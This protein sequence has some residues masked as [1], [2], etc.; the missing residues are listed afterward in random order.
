MHNLRQ[1]PLPARQTGLRPSNAV[2]VHRSE[3]VRLGGRGWTFWEAPVIGK[4]ACHFAIDAAFRVAEFVRIPTRH[5]VCQEFSRIPLRKIAHRSLNV[6]H[7]S[8]IRA[9][10]ARQPRRA[11]RA[12]STF[13]EIVKEQRAVT[14]S[15]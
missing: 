4:R 3:N 14:L 2:V 5:Q 11:R 13:Y 9:P 6:M 10:G 15:P 12:V 7:E 1:L 8:A